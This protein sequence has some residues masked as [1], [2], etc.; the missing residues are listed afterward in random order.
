[1]TKVLVV[2]DPD[3][4]TQSALSRALVIAG[5]TDLEIVVASFVA[6]EIASKVGPVRQQRRAELDNL[7]QPLIDQQ[8][9]VVSK[10]VYF[11]K[12]YD[13]II[14]LA[15]EENVDYVFKPVRQHSLM[16]RMLL[17]ATDWNLIR[18]CPMPILFTSIKP[19]IGTSVV[20]AVD[21]SSTQK[22]NLDVCRNVLSQG[23]MV[24]NLLSSRLYLTH[25]YM[26]PNTAFGYSTDD[27]SAG[28]LIK[29]LK[30]NL[31]ETSAELASEFEIPN[32]QVMLRPGLTTDV[33]NDVAREKDAGLIVI[34]TVA[35]TGFS[36]LFVGNTAEWVLEHS[37]TDVLVVKQPDFIAP[38]NLADS[39]KTRRQATAKL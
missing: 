12:L 32:E 30:E 9:K 4:S 21:L 28:Y 15:I 8:L 38:I 34:S 2:T 3:K 16:R 19:V 5:R 29:G 27:A 31:L 26:Y 13:A 37:N 25:A 20:A 24:A 17:N 10:L 11:R 33:L 6:S 39:A 35:R 18:F 36:G 23:K 7:V 14:G 1:M 22:E